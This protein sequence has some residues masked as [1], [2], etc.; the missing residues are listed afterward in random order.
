MAT[1]TMEHYRDFI[2]SLAHEMA[3]L[4]TE[5]KAWEHSWERGEVDYCDSFEYEGMTQTFAMFK[6]IQD[7]FSG[8]TDRWATFDSLEALRQYVDKLDKAYEAM[9]EYSMAV[10]PVDGQ[11][12]IGVTDEEWNNLESGRYELGKAR[13]AWN[14][15]A[16]FCE[17][18]CIS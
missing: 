14:I 11:D 17:H 16:D 4:N 18:G 1:I 7:F 12:T 2:G 6:N 5:I 13:T 15:F 8:N 3:S 9:T 10:L